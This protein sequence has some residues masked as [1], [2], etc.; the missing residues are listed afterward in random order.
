VALLVVIVGLGA[1]RGTMLF[2]ELLPWP[3]QPWVRSCVAAVLAGL[4][5]LLAGERG[6]DW[7]LLAAGGWGASAIFHEVA[8]VLSM[9]SDWLKQIVILRATNRHR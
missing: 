9:V 8:A 6:P 4:L 2:V 7:G 1:M 5:A 3:P